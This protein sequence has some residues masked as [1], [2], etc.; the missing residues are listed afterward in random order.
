M[1][2]DVRFT[3]GAVSEILIPIFVKRKQMMKSSKKVISFVENTTAYH[4]KLRPQKV[5]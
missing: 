1:F 2:D 5:L 4:A 3:F